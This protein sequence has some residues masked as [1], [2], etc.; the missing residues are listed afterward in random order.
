MTRTLRITALAVCGAWL[1]IIVL[2]GAAPFTV[3]FDDAY[4]Y[5]QIGREI[6]HGHGSTFNGL[7]HTNGY[8]PLWQGI[9]A[10]PYL[11]GFSGLAAVRAL[12]VLQLLLWAATLWVIA[13]IVGPRLSRVSTGTVAV[14]MALIAGNPY[15]LK[16]FVNGLESGVTALAYAGLIAA[17]L[18]RNERLMAVMLVVAFLGRTDAVFVIACLF[19]ATR[20]WQRFV[21]VG[22]V[23][24]VYLL[25]NQVVFGSP[26]QVSGV[27]KRQ[28][29]TAGRL[30]AVSVVALVA[31][32]VG[33]GA[34]RLASDRFAR[35]TSF[36]AETSWFAAAC[37]LLVGYYRVLS[38][39]VYLW[40]YAPVA[41]YLFMLLLHAAGDFAEGVVAE[42]QSLRTVQAIL[43]LPFALAF[44]FSAR[45]ITDPELR[46]LQEGDRA[47]AVWVRENTPSNVVIASWDAGVVG[48]FSDRPV[49]NLDGVVNSFEWE[50]A[51]HHAPAETA[52]FLLDRGVTLI[53][54]HGELV[55]G[56][57][58]DIARNVEALLGPTFRVRQV[59]R[60]EYVYSG[61]AGG[62][63][64]TRRMATF[65]YE[66]GGYTAPLD[67]TAIELPPG[68]TPCRSDQLEVASGNDPN[69]L[70]FVNRSGGPCGLA[71]YATVL[72][73]S[74]TGGFQPVPTSPLPFAAT[75]GPRWTGVFEPNL[76]AVVSLR[77]S[78][79]T[80]CAV[81]AIPA[82]FTALRLV[83]PGGTGTIDFDGLAFDTTPC[84]LQLTPFAADSQ[85]Q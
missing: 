43:V 69:L 68:V 70:R 77:P 62:Q 48:Y 23:A 21:P 27:I 79:E 16:I 57:D 46:S 28:P 17:V 49:V 72:G 6:A 31:L 78:T 39:E 85:D 73:K 80:S 38:V 82:H 66:L 5:F 4:Y 83:L 19:V 10:L 7:D 3:T 37:V 12:L 35:T 65:V 63:S 61:T 56:E 20:A 54:N 50:R 25:A 75:N 40:Y 52:R 60:E 22:A 24:A 32:A 14:L 33:I 34:R 36:L 30:V 42:G 1:P 59:H 9:C 64:G 53:V 47:A 58:P 15:V 18:K 26:L 8:H 81:A 2:W 51:R 76:V 13:G 55:N 29:L 67:G 84:P 44:V 11:V 71:G 74:S 45:Q 41:L